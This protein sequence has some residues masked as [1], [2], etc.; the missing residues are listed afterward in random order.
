MELPEF[1]FLKILTGKLDITC[2]N[3]RIEKKYIK[4]PVYCIPTTKEFLFS[5]GSL[6]FGGQISSM[7]FTFNSTSCKVP[8]NSDSNLFHIYSDT[9][10]GF[11]PILPFLGMFFF[12][13]CDILGT[14]LC[15]SLKSNQLQSSCSSA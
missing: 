12:N 13:H 11:S 14:C 2:N 5:L 10:F 8:L 1:F 4:L 15:P 9:S 7:G 3:R 6:S